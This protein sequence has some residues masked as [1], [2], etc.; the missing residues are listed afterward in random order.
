MVLYCLRPTAR[1]FLDCFLENYEKIMQ[2]TK[3]LQILLAS[4]FLKL[5]VSEL[6]RKKSRRR[7]YYI[8]R[9]VLQTSDMYCNF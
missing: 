2:R 9:F 8:L 5:M 4:T 6:R 3:L 1:F 7:V